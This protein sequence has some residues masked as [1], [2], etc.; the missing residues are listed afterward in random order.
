MYKIAKK[1]FDLFFSLFLLFLLAP[2]L[3]FLAI[4]VKLTSRGEVFFKQNRVGLEGK[5][6]KIIKFRTMIVNAES[7]GTG[8]D[9]YSDDPR[10]TRI[11]KAL[12]N[13]S[14]DELPQIFN[15]L[16]GD[17]SFVGPRPPVVYSPYRYEDY[18]KEAKVRFNIKPGVTGWAQVNGRNEL[19]WEEK[20]KFDN[21]YLQKQSFWFDIK[22]ILLTVIKVIKNEGAFDSSSHKERN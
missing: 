7:Q 1:I 10:V 19:S 14:L 21:E 2:L 17:M 6:F 12:R 16:K 4:C 22:I 11:G 3:L 18:P 8:L 15:I 5:V 9:S 20:F 13:S